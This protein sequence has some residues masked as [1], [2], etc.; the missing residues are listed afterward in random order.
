MG[1][2]SV[3]C[4]T[5]ARSNLRWFALLN[6]T[7]NE[8]VTVGD[9]YSHRSG[10][11]HRAGDLLEDIAYDQKTILERLRYLPLAPFPARTSIRTSV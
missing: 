9:L 4:D 7:V 1:I 6:L 11:P 5:P 3:P 10:L 2:G 8:H